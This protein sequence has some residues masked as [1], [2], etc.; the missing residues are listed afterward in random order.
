MDVDKIKEMLE[1]AELEM[2][3][4]EKLP[5]K[6]RKDTIYLVKK[7]LYAS[8]FNSDEVEVVDTYFEQYARIYDEWCLV[9]TLKITQDDTEVEPHNLV[10]LRSNEVR[11]E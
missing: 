11:N 7:E 9:G 10:P 6:G 4:V 5:E 1:D 8:E 2:T 3:L